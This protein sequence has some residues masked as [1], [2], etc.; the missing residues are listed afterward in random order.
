MKSG[1]IKISDLMSESCVSFGTSGARGLSTQITDLVAYA[2]TMAFLQYLDL[3]DED[4][5]FGVAGDLRP[6]TGR[7]KNSV[8]EAAF[9]CGYTVVDFGCIPSPAI[10]L[11][12]I[13][14]G[15]PTVMVTGSHIPADRNGIKFTKPSGEISKADE[16][17]IK[18]QVVFIPDGLFSTNGQILRRLTG[19]SESDE[20]LVEYI[21]RFRRAFPKDLLN[22]KKIGIYQH[23]A[24]GRDIMVEI[25]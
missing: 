10:A 17:A 7:I 6:S 14:R 15:I 11:Y 1:E 8:M 25:I 12:G 24:V 4:K 3:P 13:S 22:G 2:Y 19:F 20:G 18:E 21:A 9:D 23:S 5:M 16:Q